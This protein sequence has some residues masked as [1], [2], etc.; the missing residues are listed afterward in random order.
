MSYEGWG[1]TNK[2]RFSPCSQQAMREFIVSSGGF[3][4]N[5]N[6]MQ[7]NLLSSTDAIGKRV[8]MEELCKKVTEKADATVLD[9]DPDALCRVLKCKYSS[10]KG[11]DTIE[12][13]PTMIGN[14]ASCGKGGVKSYIKS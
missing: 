1:S 8:T 9:D 2:Y 4:L 12:T 3:C 13:L 5:S 7:K 6:S 10:G 11:M 14:D